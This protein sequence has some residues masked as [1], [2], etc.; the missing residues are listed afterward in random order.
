MAAMTFG[1]ALDHIRNMHTKFVKPFAQLEAVMAVALEVEAGLAVKQRQLAG[2]EAAI[3]T[4]H[5]RVAEAEQAGTVTLNEIAATIAEVRRRQAS[6]EAAEQAVLT[7]LKNL[8]AT[9]RIRLH[10]QA[11]TL[12]RIA[13]AA[14]TT[15]DQQL[16]DRRTELAALD[17]TKAEIEAAIAK[18]KHRFG[19]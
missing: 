6:A 18:L 13:E 3:S 10:E 4:Q 19:G 14:R 1:E 9:E 8:E 5:A 12:E 11:S 2:I 16:A 15:L 7:R 17:T